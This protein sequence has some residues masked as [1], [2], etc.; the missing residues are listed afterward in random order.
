[1][2]NHRAAWAPGSGRRVCPDAAQQ[3]AAGSFEA[4]NPSAVWLSGAREEER[5]RKGKQK[6]QEIAFLRLD[7]FQVPLRSCLMKYLDSNDVIFIPACN[8]CSFAAYIIT[9][10]NP[11]MDWVRTISK[12]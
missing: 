6:L 8:I 7:L 4:E 3:R 11:T 9:R 10:S 2:A 12:T 5:R 1:M